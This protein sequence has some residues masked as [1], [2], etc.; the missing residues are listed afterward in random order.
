MVI[1]MTDSKI[2]EDSNN[3]TLFISKKLVN[4]EIL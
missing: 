1:T 4:L 2:I 3:K